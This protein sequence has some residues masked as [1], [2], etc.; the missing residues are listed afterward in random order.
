MASV[1]DLLYAIDNLEKR[2][3]GARGYRLQLPHFSLRRGEKIAIIGESG[4]GK[5]TALDILGFVLAPDACDRFVFQSE[6][7]SWDILEFFR[8]KQSERLCSLRL[9]HVGYVLQT[10]E[11]LPF[12]NVAQNM[13]L[14][15]TMRG[16]QAEEALDRAQRLAGK[17][18][19]AQ[20]MQ[21]LPATLSVGERQRVAIVRAL[22][23]SPEII[24]ADEPTAALDP[25]HAQCVMQAFLEAVDDEGATLILVS[26]NVSLVRSHAL[27]EWH[28]VLEESEQGTTARLMS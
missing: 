8:L 20:K 5:S 11:L 19:I 9:K 27:R 4:C 7:Q 6:Q 1:H 17:L 28:F 10:G 21:A 24:L 14:V 22:L 25:M 26:H 12:L 3:Q 18:G 13:T 23:P 15:A 16:M 2:R